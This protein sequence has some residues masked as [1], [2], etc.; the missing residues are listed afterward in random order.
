M[1]LSGIDHYRAN[2]Y[3]R[4]GSSTSSQLASLLGRSSVNSKMLKKAYSKLS[5]KTGKTYLNRTD[6][7]ENAVSKYYQS[8][9]LSETENASTLRK[10]ASEM[11]LA[12]ASLMKSEKLSDDAL[13]SKVKD[14]AESYN[15]AVKALANTSSY[16]VKL[17]G[18]SMT[19]ITDSFEAS[20]SKAGIT[21]NEDKTLTVDEKVLKENRSQLSSLFKSGYSFGA[22]M[23][24]KGSELQSAAQ[25]T[26]LSAAGI[27]NRYGSF[28]N[29]SNE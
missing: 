26:G 1:S 10:N 17:T 3:K 5:R 6:T 29:S 22:K 4:S 19:G 9:S 13:V 23:I 20:L 11:S 24:K 16:A 27:Y 2:M 21:V 7:S 18:E 15:G 28:L 8:G 14:F 12:A 25:L